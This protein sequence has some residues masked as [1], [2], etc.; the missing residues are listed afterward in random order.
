MRNSLLLLLAI[1]LWAAQSEPVAAVTGG[2]IRGSVLEKGGA[3][4]KGIPFA[5]PPVGELRWREPMAVKSWSGVR[6]ASEFGPP[7]AQT[8]VFPFG[9]ADV[10]KEDCLYLNVWTNEWPSGSPKPVM[11]WIP[12]GGNFGGAAS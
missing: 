8:A 10:S 5:Q 11:V 2:Q 9:L 1:P 4:F 12:G 7:C 3:A 6:N